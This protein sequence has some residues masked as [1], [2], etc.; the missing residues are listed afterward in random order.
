MKNFNKNLVELVK[1]EEGGIVHVNDEPA[2]ILESDPNK[3]EGFIKMLQ[4]SS[5]QSETG[6]W[7]VMNRYF[8]YFGKVQALMNFV[9]ERVDDSGKLPG[10]IMIKEF[11]KSEVPEAF[12]KLFY[13]RKAEI[14]EN[15]F[16]KTTG[17]ENPV[18][19]YN[20]GELIMRFPVWFEY[21][22]ENAFDVF[23]PYDNKEEVM[24]WRKGNPDTTIEGETP[25]E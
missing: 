9:N 2:N 20:G 8:T 7:N 10:R 17:G 19:L 4:R 21:Q 18:K 16:I 3:Q 6:Y 15:F 22:T 11:R 13:N 12:K 24:K 1:N 23:L 5:K 14:P 25:T